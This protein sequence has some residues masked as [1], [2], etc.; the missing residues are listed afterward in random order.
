MF[1]G[2]SLRRDSIGKFV[3]TFLSESGIKCAFVPSSRT[4]TPTGIRYVIVS[5]PGNIT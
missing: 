4:T 5:F 2:Y 1:F 3:H